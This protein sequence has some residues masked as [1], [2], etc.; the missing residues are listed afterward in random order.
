MEDSDFDKALI[1]SAF[2]AA[3]RAGWHHVGVAEAARSAGLP[4]ARARVRFPNRAAILLR[5][6]VLTDQVGA[7]A[8]HGARAGA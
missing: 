6:G 7:R 1:A 5:F 8:V 3:A 4:L 2:G